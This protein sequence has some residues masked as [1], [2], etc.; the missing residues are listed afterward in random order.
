[1]SR[2]ISHP[3]G[4][5]LL[6]VKVGSAHVF[7]LHP[8]EEG[9]TMTTTLYYNSFPALQV[10]GWEQSH[11]AVRGEQHFSRAQ[12]VVG[13]SFTPSPY[14][15]TGHNVAMQ[16][17]GSQH[18][19]E[20]CETGGYKINFWS[21]VAIY[22]REPLFN[23]YPSRKNLRLTR[24]S[25]SMDV[26][27]VNTGAWFSAHGCSAR[28]QGHSLAGSTLCS[29]SRAEG[30]LPAPVR[31]SQASRYATTSLPCSLFWSAWKVDI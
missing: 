20:S 11:P 24:G 30:R 5:H 27:T 22:S 18:K 29:S 21:D 7:F 15:T 31:I 12:A 2:G 26:K 4:F 13:K 6:N 23:F 10:A 9:L 16:S 8:V 17:S 25:Y 1:M 14:T 19:G 3:L 28:G